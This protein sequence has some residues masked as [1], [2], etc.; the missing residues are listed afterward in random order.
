[1]SDGSVSDYDND[2]VVESKLQR[3]GDQPVRAVY[4]YRLILVVLIPSWQSS[5]RR[6][7]PVRASSPRFRFSIQNLIHL[8]L[9]T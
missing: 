7:I 5:K 9:S 2:T 8:I 3:T 1:M 6:R 4:Y